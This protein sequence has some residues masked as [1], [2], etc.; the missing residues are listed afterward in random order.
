MTDR[1]VRKVPVKIVGNEEK[2]LEEVRLRLKYSPTNPTKF[3]NAVGL[4]VS[5]LNVS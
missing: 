3:L 1:S 4:P 2:R 5:F